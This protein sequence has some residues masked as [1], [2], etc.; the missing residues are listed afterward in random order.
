MIWWC[1]TAIHDA[2]SPAAVRSHQHPGER[3]PLL[4]SVRQRAAAADVHLCIHR[5]QVRQQVLADRALLRHLLHSLRLHRH[6]HLKPWSRATVRP[7]HRTSLKS[8]LLKPEVSS[9]M[10]RWRWRGRGR[11]TLRWQPAC[12]QPQAQCRL[13]A[14]RAPRNKPQTV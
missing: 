4:P 13:A 9:G 5:C 1:V 11:H 3:V 7:S 12:G 2:S 14:P 10:C 8:V 6:L